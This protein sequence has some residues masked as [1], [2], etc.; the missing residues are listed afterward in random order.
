MEAGKNIVARCKED[1]RSILFSGISLGMESEAFIADGSSVARYANFQGLF[2][3]LDAVFSKARVSSDETLALYV[4]NSSEAA[5]I[6][7]YLTISGLSFIILRKACDTEPDLPYPEF[8]SRAIK[9]A[10]ADTQDASIS[11]LCDRIKITSGRDQDQAAIRGSG[12]ACFTYL[13]TSGSLGS[14]K[15]VKFVSDVFVK[16]S[17]LSLGRTG[18]SSKDRVIIPVPIHHMYGLGAGLL[19]A[20]M[21]G[22]SIRLVENANVVSFLEAEREFYPTVAF[23]TPGLC[24]ML[25]GRV[26]EGN[27]Y[28][29]AVSAGDKISKEMALS[30]EGR[31][32]KVLSLYGST[33]MGVIATSMPEHTDAKGRITLCPLPG[34]EIKIENEFGGQL[35]E[36]T[37][38]IKCRHPYGFAGYT[39]DSALPIVDSTTDQNGWFVT[40]DMGTQFSQNEFEVVGR[41]GHSVNRDGR[42]VFLAEIEEAMRKIPS[43]EQ[44]A[45]VTGNESPRGRALIAF[46]VV[47]PDSEA[48]P[49]ELRRACKHELPAFAV[50]DELVMVSSIPLLS[51]GKIDRLSL[52]KILKDNHKE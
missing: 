16:N 44:V 51:G 46:C 35:A 28:R 29:Y 12:Q 21:A 38:A 42:L 18:I 43:L 10:P 39:D 2:L 33:E 32:S 14:P 48:T 26:C 22:A 47:A 34:V 11:G 3:S 31:F 15:Y 41:Q 45:V 50:P 30:L 23:L 27:S 24:K 6:L 52:K 19:P 49:A 36:G 1:I 17:M 25:S 20:I 37:G 4:D 9:I 5:I 8:C 13:K 40:G 7:L